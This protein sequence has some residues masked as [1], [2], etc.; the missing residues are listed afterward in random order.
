[1]EIIT[2]NLEHDYITQTFE[3]Y[4]VKSVTEIEKGTIFGYISG[5][6][7]CSYDI[8]GVTPG[9]DKP[10]P[11]IFEK[12]EGNLAKELLTGNVFVMGMTECAEDINNVGDRRLSFEEFQKAYD[13]YKDSN[14]YIDIEKIDDTKKESIC[15]A[16][17]IDDKFKSIYNKYTL[18]NKENVINDINN[19]TGKAHKFFVEDFEE[20][21]EEV[22]GLANVDYFLSGIQKTK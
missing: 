11:L 4:D 12:L 10:T 5:T 18:E 14:V 7:Q 15:G 13:T 17:V 21:I 22:R 16:F 8:D 19:I 1:M 9:L 20:V 6:I 3:L 2:K